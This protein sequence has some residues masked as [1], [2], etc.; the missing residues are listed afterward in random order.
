MPDLL[1]HEGDVVLGEP[2]AKASLDLA[3]GLFIGARHDES[4]AHGYCR[5]ARRPG[6]RE[7]AIGRLG[8]RGPTAFNLRSL[9]MVPKRLA[10][11]L[12]DGDTLL[13]GATRHALPELRIQPYRLDRCRP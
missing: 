7:G 3:D 6:Q 8:G 4:L 5:V 12:R 1:S 9:E 2:E 13:L 11:D 10:D